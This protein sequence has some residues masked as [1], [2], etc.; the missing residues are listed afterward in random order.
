MKH[1]APSQPE[2][3]TAKTWHPDGNVKVNLNYDRTHFFS[4]TAPVFSQDE[5]V[6]F[7]RVPV[8]L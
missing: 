6:T 3:G 1:T 8:C 7:N 2:I 4:A 5:Q